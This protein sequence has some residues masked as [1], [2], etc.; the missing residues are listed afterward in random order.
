MVTW[1]KNVSNFI[2]AQVQPQGIAH[3]LLEHSVYTLSPTFY[4]MGW[5]S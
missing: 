4:W 1:M 2:I 5:E 3:D